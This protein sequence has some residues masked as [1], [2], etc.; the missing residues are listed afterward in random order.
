[1][2]DE[3]PGVVRFLLFPASKKAPPPLQNPG[4]APV[5]YSKF[6]QQATSSAI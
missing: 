1:M 3:N 4:N 6:C 5:N 2:T